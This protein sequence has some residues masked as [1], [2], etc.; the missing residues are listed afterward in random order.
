MIIAEI[1][2]KYAKRLSLK[3]APENKAIAPIAVK[4]NGWGI[5]LVIAASTIKSATGRT[6]FFVKILFM[7]RII[8]PTNVAF[9][10]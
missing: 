6:V 3:L 4:L 2:I 7:N 5:S 9:S 10:H 1:G 8:F